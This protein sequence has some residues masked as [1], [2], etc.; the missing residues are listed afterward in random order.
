MPSMADGVLKGQQGAGRQP[1]EISSSKNNGGP[2]KYS[3]SSCHRRTLIK[4]NTTD[5]PRVS[6]SGGP[7]SLL[8]RPHHLIPSTK[9]RGRG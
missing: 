3:D 8:P 9:M 5:T 4:E 1:P 2:D 7:R 6:F